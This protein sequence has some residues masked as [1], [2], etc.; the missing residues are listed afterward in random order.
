[1]WMVLTLKGTSLILQTG[2]GMRMGKNG[3]VINFS[4][5]TVV[6]KVPLSKGFNPLVLQW[7]QLTLQ[8][9]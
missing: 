9:V 2:S 4:L 1:M 6:I 3:E 5:L 8:C 7:Y